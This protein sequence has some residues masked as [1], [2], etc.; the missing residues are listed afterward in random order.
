MSRSLKHYNVEELALEVF[1]KLGYE[2]VHGPD[3]A[4]DAP[5][6]ERSTYSDVVL[7]GRLEEAIQR[8]NRHAGEDAIREARRVVLLAEAPTVLENNRRFHRLLRDGMELEL[9]RDGGEVRGERLRLFDF[10]D[11]DQNDWLVVNQLTIVEG[12]ANRRPDLVVFVNGLPLGVE[13]ND[14]AVSVLGDSV[15]TQI[16]RELTTTIRNSVTIDWTQKET[17]RA[18]LRTL[19]RRK[20]RQV[21]YPPDKT[22]KAVETVIKQAELLAASWAA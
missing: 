3:I 7:I 17:V 22:E 18:K 15:L 20:L 5:D 21:G 6:A 13:T 8:L 1:A 19:V 14:S 2:V 4:P 11:A 10:D 16:A 9:A 12:Q